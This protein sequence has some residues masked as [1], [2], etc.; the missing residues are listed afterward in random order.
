MTRRKK[1]IGSK[2]TRK[3]IIVNMHENL[4]NVNNHSK[5]EVKHIGVR[6]G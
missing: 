3:K 4:I 1:S 6:F 5:P 2:Q